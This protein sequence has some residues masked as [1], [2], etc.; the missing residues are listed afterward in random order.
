MQKLQK[1]SIKEASPPRR[2]EFRKQYAVG[3]W[4]GLLN[5]DK[6]DEECPGHG[7]GEN[8]SSKK[9]G[10]KYVISILAHFQISKLIK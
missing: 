6:N 2:G 5:R 8:D 9:A 4:G 10:N 7:T 3:N 1:L